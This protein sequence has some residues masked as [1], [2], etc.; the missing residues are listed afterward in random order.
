MIRQSLLSFHMWSLFSPN[1]ETEI[2][3]STE[4]RRKNTDVKQWYDAEC[5]LCNYYLIVCGL[6][7]NKYFI[8]I[9]VLC[10]IF[11]VERQQISLEI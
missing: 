4:C 11:Q 7:V 3:Q 6:G 9:I 10:F 1:P 5:F 2:P 8:L